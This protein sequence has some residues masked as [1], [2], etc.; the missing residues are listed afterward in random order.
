MAPC[1]CGAGHRVLGAGG[2]EREVGRWVERQVMHKNLNRAAS[3]HVNSP[4]STI[5]PALSARRSPTLRALIPGTY[6]LFGRLYPALTDFSDV[7]ARQAQSLRSPRPGG[8]S[9]F[10]RCCPA[11]LVTSPASPCR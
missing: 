8:L 7:S 11:C 1:A 6:R 2:L 3:T 9:L 10:G 5:R 4:E